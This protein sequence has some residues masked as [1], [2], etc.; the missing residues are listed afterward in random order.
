MKRTSKVSKV[1]KMSRQTYPTKKALKE[2]RFRQREADRKQFEKP[3]RKFIEHKYVDIYEEYNQL[4]QTMVR[5]HPG[6]KNL[7]ETS[8][9]KDAIGQTTRNAI[10]QTVPTDI[11]STALKETFGQNMFEQTEV[12]NAAS[13]EPRSPEEINS[14]NDDQNQQ[15]QA[16]SDEIDKDDE[17]RS[18]EEI[19]SQNDDQNQQDQAVSDEIAENEA[20]EAERALIDL[21]NE[22]D[23]IIEELVQ[24]EFIRDI[25]DPQ[26]E[27]EGIEL[28]TFD[29]M[30]FDAIEDF[31]FELEVEQPDEGYDW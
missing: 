17:P 22:A 1:K 27:D 31:D 21:R 3:L 28:N 29:D 7:L 25:L 13:D 5:N 23:S 16:V 30:M 10:C 19:N 18:P 26:P 2:R 12:V 15:D 11:L 8:T 4:Y 14:Q 20:L 6:V 9:F 24:N